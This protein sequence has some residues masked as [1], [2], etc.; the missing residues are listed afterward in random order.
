MNRLYCCELVKIA[1]RKSLYA[2][3]LA[4]LLIWCG[5]LNMLCSDRVMPA[6]QKA[7]FEEIRRSGQYDSVLEEYEEISAQVSALSNPLEPEK[8]GDPY[9][10][11][12]KYGA[13]LAEDDALLRPVAA[14][15]RY[16]REY[17]EYIR[18]IQ[19]QAQDSYEEAL[20]FR[21]D[22]EARRAL[23]ILDAYHPELEI[24]MLDDSGWTSYFQNNGYAVFILL[25]LALITIPLFVSDYETGVHALVFSTQS[26]RGRLFFAK[27]LAAYTAGAA[28]TLIF[29]V[30]QFACHAARFD[31]GQADSA[32]Q[33]ISAF[34]FCPYSISIFSGALL[35]FLWAAAGSLAA[36]SLLALVS[37]A[38]RKSLPSFLLSVMIL[39]P[40]YGVNPAVSQREGA[41]FS[42][43]KEL[44]YKNSHHFNFIS[45]ADSAYYF[46]AYRNVEWFGLPVDSILC[47]SAVSMLIVFL[48][49]FPAYRLFSN[50]RLA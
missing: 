15:I 44:I 11:P 37:C 27:L 36:V 25:L 16:M 9:L 24:R 17:P 30:F 46:S 5:Y 47:L 1:Q 43:A 20:A 41:P 12:G 49:L 14:R 7:L 18:F 8:A 33:N 21:N 10:I 4:F 13:S 22:Y 34:R 39:G 31:M 23:H 29:H 2:F 50:K 42:L 45:L 3:L 38:F 19:N 32:I 48:S 26:G 6:E 28:V 35:S 40:L